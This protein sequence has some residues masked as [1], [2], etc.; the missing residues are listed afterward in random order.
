[1]EALA[2]FILCSSPRK[3]SKSTWDCTVENLGAPPGGHWAPTGAAGTEIHPCRAARQQQSI[4]GMDRGR[5]TSV[6]TAEQGAALRPLAPD[7]REAQQL[8]QTSESLNSTESRPSHSWEFL[9]QNF[10]W[11]TWIIPSSAPSA[12]LPY[13][14]PNPS[15]GSHTTLD[16]GTKPAPGPALPAVPGAPGRGCSSWGPPARNSTRT[17]GRLWRT[18]PCAWQNVSAVLALQ[19]KAF[20]L[21]SFLTTF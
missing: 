1:M 13:Q 19:F 17:R 7:Q 15:P 3:A 5:R 6:H 16:P 12:A 8:P 2:P 4:P 20:P 14:H 9:R 21:L 10:T 11:R 18:A